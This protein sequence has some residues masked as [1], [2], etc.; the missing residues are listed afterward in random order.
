MEKIT[1]KNQEE[2]KA[3]LYAYEGGKTIYLVD[4]MEIVQKLKTMGYRIE[5][6]VIGGYWKVFI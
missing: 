6:H 5:E 2:I 3:E 4:D 1:L